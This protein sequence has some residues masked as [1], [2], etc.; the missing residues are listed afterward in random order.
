[1]ASRQK[2]SVPEPPRPQPQIIQYEV[3]TS[4]YERPRR[5][6]TAAAAA[7]YYYYYCSSSNSKLLPSQYCMHAC[8][9]SSSSSSIEQQQQQ[10]ESTGERCLAAFSSAQC[11]ENNT[12]IRCPLYIKSALY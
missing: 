9:S 3:F 7:E 4:G 1:M 12:H 5:P 2:R 8:S 11:F 6:H 10:Q